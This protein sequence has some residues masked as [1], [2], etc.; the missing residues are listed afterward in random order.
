M[1]PEFISLLSFTKREVSRLLRVWKQTIVPPIV[2]SL[3]YI[4]IF[5]YSLGTKITDIGGVSYLEFIFPGL[6]MMGV[7]S[8]SY[9]NTSSSLYISKFQGNI[10]EVLVAP[11]S[12]LSIIFALATGS[13][14]RSTLVAV[15]TILIGSL[16]AGLSI[17]NVGIILY[18]LFSSILLFAFAGILTGLWA[19]SFDQMSVFATFVVTPLT[20]LGGVFYSIDMLPGFWRTFSL[21]NPIYYLVDG[22]RYGFFGTSSSPLWASVL[23]TTVLTFSF[24]ALCIHLFRK[25][26]KIRT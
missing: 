14:V 12:Y 10:Q 3:L 6:I 13:V 4:L 26:Y 11:I 21:F 20:Y 16:F 22:F 8:S 7:I 25:G 15:G 19:E 1:N 2:T 24:G 23:I 9:S 5:G 18:F 17:V